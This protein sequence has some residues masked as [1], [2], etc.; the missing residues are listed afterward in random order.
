MSIKDKLKGLLGE[1]E[2]PKFSDF[3]PEQVQMMAEYWLNEITK[4][5]DQANALLW[6]IDMEEKEYIDHA[7]AGFRARKDKVITESR[8]K[9]KKLESLINALRARLES[10]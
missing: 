9:I 8:E 10:K 6:Q 7:K 5:E 4:I 2:P 3:T 1:E